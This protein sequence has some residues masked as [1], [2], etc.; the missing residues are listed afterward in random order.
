MMVPS[1]Y[2]GRD[3]KKLIPKQLV[4]PLMIL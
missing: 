4:R 1:S 3:R 2:I